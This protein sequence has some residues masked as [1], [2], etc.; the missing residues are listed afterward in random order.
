M[1]SSLTRRVVLA[2]AV[3][4]VGCAPESNDDY[5]NRTATKGVNTGPQSYSS[6]GGQQAPGAEGAMP[7]APASS[8][9]SARTRSQ[10]G[11]SAT[12]V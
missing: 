9:S 5:F 7:A 11:P 4:L 3:A 8:G 6:S 1:R 12:A 10:V 2:A